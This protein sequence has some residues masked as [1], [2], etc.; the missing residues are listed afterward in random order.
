MVFDWLW[1][2]NVQNYNCDYIKTFLVL[3]RKVFRTRSPLFKVYSCSKAL[4]WV[5]LNG[6]QWGGLRAVEHVLGTLRWNIIVKYSNHLNTILVGWSENRTEKACQWSK[7]SGIW[8]QDT[9]TVQYNSDESSVQFF[10]ILL[11]QSQSK[12]IFIIIAQDN[13]NR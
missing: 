10:G 12:I 5:L 11:V 8:I 1:I 6:R 13:H 3:E 7:M 2:L 4:G 9:H